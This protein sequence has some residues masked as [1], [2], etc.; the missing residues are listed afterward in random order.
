LNGLIQCYKKIEY[1]FLYFHKGINGIL[2]FMKM[3]KIFIFL[4]YFNKVIGHIGSHILSS[5][6]WIILK[7]KFRIRVKIQF[8]KIELVLKYI[9]LII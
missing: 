4:V 2:D 9:F 7:Y 1:S 8:Y 3:Q 5:R 6:Y